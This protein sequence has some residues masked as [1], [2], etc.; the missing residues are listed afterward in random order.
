[1]SSPQKMWMISP[2]K[3]RLRSPQK[4]WLRSSLKR[5]INFSFLTLSPFS[6]G[7]TSLLYISLS[8]K[9]VWRKVIFFTFLL[10]V[11]LGRNGKCPFIVLWHFHENVTFWPTNQFTGLCACWNILLGKNSFWQRRYF[12][13]FPCRLRLK[14]CN[15]FRRILQFDVTL[16]VE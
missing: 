15:F 12:W 8:L 5:E 1:M 6:A 3:M 14:I 7:E 9:Y 16:R 2:Q 4:M 10:G 13:C 11:L